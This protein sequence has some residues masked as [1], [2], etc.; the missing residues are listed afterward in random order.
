MTHI[1]M[2]TYSSGAWGA[3]TSADQPHKHARDGRPR[4]HAAG[5]LPMGHIIL[6]S[7]AVLVVIA[8]ALLVTLG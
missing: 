3:E 5:S 7:T 6:L 8:A 2:T 1:R 4:H